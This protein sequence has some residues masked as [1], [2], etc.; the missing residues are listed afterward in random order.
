MAKQPLSPFQKFIR[1]ESL[2][3]ILLLVA[4]IAALIWANSPLGDSYRS[5][6]DYKIGLKSSDIDLV[7]PL[8]LW[9]NDG[10]M[11]I[12]FFLIGLEIKRELMIGELNSPKKAA[13]PF[14][15]AIGGMAVPAAVF[16]LL[17][18]N[19]EAA[20]GWGIPIATD[21]AFS[22][23]ILKLL[24]NRVP[25]SLKVFLTA[26][27][28]AD[29]LGAVIVIA[30]FYSTGINWLLLLT[31]LAIVAFLGVLSY[32]QYFSKY[33]H[34]ILGIITWVLFL[35]AGIHP[36][37]AGVLLAVTVPIRQRI[38]LK[39]FTGNLDEMGAVLRTCP[40]NSKPV[41]T[42]RQIEIMD[43]LEDWT[44]RVRSP[45]QHLEHIL[46]NW[47]AWLIMPLFALANAGVSFSGSVQPDMPLISSLALSL[48]F[49]KS[50]GI[51]LVSYIGIKTRI[52]ELPNGV[53]MMQIIGVSF[54]AGVGFTMSIFIA[55]LAFAGNPALGDSSIMGILAG[56]VIAG[57]LGYL[58]LRVNSKRS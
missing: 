14:I 1:I 7:K 42:H 24:G 32:Y 15:A 3:G 18:R 38:D 34:L 41:L 36:T 51:S 22:L 27:A 11:A 23:A 13:F 56:S 2:G 40:E 43:D 49:G 17:N 39:T 57:L 54:L 4:T 29:D 21:I 55:S 33:F 20:Q 16:L 12:F 6:W 30:I 25:L 26:F 47:V 52:V 31:G 53:S 19:P 48:I 9:V 35:K 8:R 45:L 28:I 58:I 44:R 50:L 37:I 5:I 46:H 10:L